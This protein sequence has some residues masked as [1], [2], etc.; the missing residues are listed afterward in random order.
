MMQM[1]DEFLLSF[2][3]DCTHDFRTF[4]FVYSLFLIDEFSYYFSLPQ[5]LPLCIGYL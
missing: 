4:V 2:C 1:G 3:Q 5:F